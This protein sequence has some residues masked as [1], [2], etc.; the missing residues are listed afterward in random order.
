MMEPLYLEKPD[1]HIMPYDGI[2]ID[3][4]KFSND[5]VLEAEKYMEDNNL[6]MIV[7]YNSIMD[8]AFTLEDIENQWT[9]FN[10][11]HLQLRRMSDWKCL[12]L[13]GMTNKDLYEYLKSNELGKDIN[14]DQGLNDTIN[15][16]ENKEIKE[17]F[18]DDGLESIKPYGSCDVENAIEWYYSTG[19]PII[20]PTDT[21]EQLETMW[22]NFN[23]VPLK[24]RR[25]S[26][27]KSVEIFGVTNLEHYVYLK[28]KFLKDDIQNYT[29]DDDIYDNEY[30]IPSDHHTFIESFVKRNMIN[31]DNIDTVISTLIEASQYDQ[32]NYYQSNIKNTIKRILED[33]E[34][35]NTVDTDFL[36]SSELPFYTPDEMIDMG[37]FSAPVDNYYG[38]EADNT[39]L[40]DDIS[41]KTWFENY[42]YHF[43]GI[44]T[45]NRQE[46][47]L[48][49]LKKLTELCT[50]LNIME[51]FGED[52]KKIK[53]K[54]Q[55]ILEL[56]WNPELSFTPENR[57]KASRMYQENNNAHVSSRFI[58]LRNIPINEAELVVDTKDKGIL[59]PVYIV[60][61]QGRRDF[62]YLIRAVTMSE[63]SHCSMSFDSDLKHLY[64][65]N[66]FGGDKNSKSYGGFEV[67]P[68]ER[69]KKSN[70][71][72]AVY[73]V[74]LKEEDY[75]TMK[76]NVEWLIEHIKETTY[77]FINLLAVAFKITPIEGDM[78]NFCSQFVDRMFKLIGVDIT[79]KK[80][81]WVVPEEFHRQSKKNNKIY[82]LFT[83]Y[84]QNF[85]G[86]K[87][88]R[89]IRQLNKRKLI[90]PIK[91]G[92]LYKDLYEE[93]L[94][95]YYSIDEI[96]YEV[97]DKTN[98]MNFSKIDSLI[99]NF[100]NM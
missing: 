81:Q 41:T 63:Y 38:I 16:P 86:I 30:I 11:M 2:N 19:Y 75:N 84:A 78:K 22:D 29:M 66:E 18:I 80:S 36:P 76:K 96:E 15:I 52:S 57:A 82:T 27:M 42:R 14:S 99:E 62:S 70:A 92:V 40:T 74:F 39:E 49:R 88:E 20:I 51:E 67:E 8:K 59:R 17:G 3:Y 50:K 94:E 46:M 13:F 97:I 23:S 4:L 5:K 26:D 87:I 44:D 32:S 60:L 71:K 65:F 25:F 58:D 95:S 90:V 69:F 64:S 43:N 21:L 10:N 79:H 61:T 72:M 1:D 100:K 98:G 7:P 68:F 89:I 35:F 33:E 45:P 6:I 47:Y 56:G 53:A 48:A 54:K 12:E 28:R 85:K 77:S 37:V 73:C 83:D 91:E 93:Y 34:I 31:H 9:R 24:Y 55:S